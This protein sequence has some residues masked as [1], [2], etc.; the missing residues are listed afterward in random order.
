MLGM[1]GNRT[2]TCNW[3]IVEA[4]VPA[5]WPDIAE[6]H[7]FVPA[8]VPT[9]LGAKVTDIRVPLRTVLYRVGTNCS[10]KT[11]A[12][13]AF[14]WRGDRCFAGGGSSV[15]AQTGTFVRK[16]GGRHGPPA[17][18]AARNCRRSPNGIRPPGPCSR[19]NAEKAAAI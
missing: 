14:C 12:A 1:D 15:G 9:Q 4:Q 16:P 19:R 2:S 5:H 6:Q 8:K 18:N 13:S 10:L 17:S 11:A 3:E 7:G